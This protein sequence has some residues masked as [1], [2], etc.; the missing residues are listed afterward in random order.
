MKNLIIDLTQ[1]PEEGA[2]F[3]GELSPE[4]FIFSSKDD[5]KALSPLKYDIFVERFES[6]LLLRGDLSATFELTC[7]IT[8]KRFSKT[9]N[10]LNSAISIEIENTSQI[11]A[12]DSIREEI[13]IELPIDPRC[14]E[15]DI[16]MEC[17][18]NSKYLAVDKSTSIELDCP[19][20]ADSRWSALDAL[21]DT[22]DN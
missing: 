16:P 17:K 6:E 13:I 10:V 14:D 7:V 20:T 3:V 8:L 12:T 11:D 5:I 9:I 4:I 19:P 21:Q 15:A 18:I 1:L 2:K 22:K